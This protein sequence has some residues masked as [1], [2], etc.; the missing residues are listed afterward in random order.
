MTGSYGRYVPTGHLLYVQEATLVAV[1][2]DLQRLEPV[3]EPVPVIEGVMGTEA[4]AGAQFA[5]SDNGTLVYLPGV[6]PEAEP[7]ISWL[8]RRAGLLR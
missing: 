1:P 6:K 7:P 3:G 5:V 4:M 2:F 8:D